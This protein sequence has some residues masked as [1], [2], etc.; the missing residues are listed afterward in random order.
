MQKNKRRTGSSIPVFSW[1]VLLLI[2]LCSGASALAADAISSLV[3]ADIIPPPDVLMPEPGKITPYVGLGVVYDSNVLRL[4]DEAQANAMGLGGMS[5]TIRRGTFGLALDKNI[6]Q[7]RITANLSATKVDYDRFAA[8]DHIDKNAALNW[9]WHAG[10]HVEGNAG[11]NYSQGL[12]PFIDF[13]ELAPNIRTQTSEYVDGAWM[14]HPSWRVRAGLTRSK[15][16]YDL[17]SQQPA[18][19]TQNQ[20]ELGLDY[21]ARSGSTIGLQA[22]HITA[23]F[24][25]PE[26]DG[27]GQQ[28]LNGYTQN[29]MKG[30]VDWLLTGKTRL[31][32]LGGWVSRKQDQFSARNFSGMNSRVSADWSPTGKIDLSAT[33]WREIGAVDDLSTVYSLNR[34]ASLASI[35]K[36]SEKIHLIGQV[37]YVKR[38]FSQ[39]TVSGTVGGATAQNDV[40]RNTGLTVAYT[41]TDK[42]EIRMSGVRSTQSSTAAD[43]GYTSNALLLNTRYAF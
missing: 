8:L 6:S 2:P 19:N 1:K 33:V 5:D 23:D 16:D 10:E 42:W 34:G 25:N 14:F 15:L 36:Y 27:N 24:P 9:N 3:P 30:K 7:Q 22:R 4:R 37:N 31:H 40:L 39:S 11:V 28:V 13:H 12:T 38:D 17:A 29:E 18:N 35:W 26:I 41:P 43:G 32:F 21:L 20:T